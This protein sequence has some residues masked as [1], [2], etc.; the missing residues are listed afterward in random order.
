MSKK[1][2]LEKEPIPLKKRNRKPENSKQPWWLRR[3]DYYKRRLLRLQGS[4]S[5]IAR[6]IAVGAFAG[7]FPIFGFQ[8]LVG[9]LLAVLLKG[10]KLAAVAATWISNPLTY[11]PIFAFNYQLG[12]WLLGTEDISIDEIDFQSSSALLEL[13]FTFVLALFVGCLVMG[14]IVSICSYFIALRGIRHFRQSHTSSKR[15]R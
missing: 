6:G 2:L 13:G 12:Q 10:H 1:Y 5:A 14:S 8:T 7:M 3:I 11:V 9:V 4:E 15:D